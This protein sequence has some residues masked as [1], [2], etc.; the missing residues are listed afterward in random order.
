MRNM[1]K[2]MNRFFKYLKNPLRAYL[3]VSFKGHFK[4]VPDRLHLKICYRAAFGK[5]LRIDA[6]ESFNEKLQWLKLYDRNPLYTTLVDKYEV[7]NWVA[8]R[9]G[10]RYVV[11]TLDL[12]E[13]IDQIDYDQLPKQF[14]LKCTHDSG[15]L[16]ICRDKDKLDIHHA[17]SLLKKALSTNYYYTAREWPYKNV[18]PRIMAEQYLDTEDSLG[19]TDYKFYCF[20]GEPQFLYVSK[21]L[22][23]HATAQISFLTL[24][25]EFAPYRRD[26]FM[27]FQELPPKPVSF[28]EMLRL[29]KILSENIPFVRV[30]FYEYR[31]KPI[32]SEMTFTPCGGF[33]KF[34]PDEWDTRIGTLLQ[35]EG[36]YGFTNPNM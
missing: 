4:W 30:D 18:H 34:A 25:W 21:G 11:P 36:A 26:D 29:S 1:V 28:D 22:E 15:G 5:K 12:F 16:I 27:P 24:Q 3:L 6:P 9:I 10:S 14:A 35:L 2:S 20:N 13:T 17:Q 32:F 31:G 8:E 19:L 7:K 23:N 33:M